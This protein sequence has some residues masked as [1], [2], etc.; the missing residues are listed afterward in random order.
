VTARAQTSSVTNGVNGA[1]IRVRLSSTSCSVARADGSPSQNRRRERRTYQ[2]DRSSTNSAISRPA[3]CVSKSSSAVV[4]PS[5]TAASSA[6]AQR[7]SSG[8]SARGGAGVA[9]GSQ[10]FASAYRVK[11]LAVFQ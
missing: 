6:S 3:P 10:P 5:V 11:K 4:T 7:S 8:R 9:A 2:L 1:M